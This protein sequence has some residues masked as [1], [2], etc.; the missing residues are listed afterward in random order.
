[1]AIPVQGPP[2]L[3]TALAMALGV[4]EFPQA[5]S[6]EALAQHL[7]IPTNLLDWTFQAKKAAYFAAA[8]AAKKGWSSGRM[9]VW[10]LKYWAFRGPMVRGLPDPRFKIVTAP[11]ATNPNLHAQAGVFT[12]LESPEVITVDDYIRRVVGEETASEES[13]SGFNL[14]KDSPW[15]RRLSVPQ[16]CARQLLCFLGYEGISASSMFPGYGGVVES[17]RELALWDNRRSEGS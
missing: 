15:M 9:D 11:R 16:S 12:T 1:M 17:L 2:P 5:S 6:L 7:G 13:P 4:G 8:A 14:S 10:A 3:Q